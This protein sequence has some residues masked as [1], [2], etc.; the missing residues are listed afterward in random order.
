M[1]TFGE[2][3]ACLSY[4]PE[5]LMAF[6]VTNETVKS[7][8]ETTMLIGQVALGIAYPV[9]IFASL[10]WLEP[11]QVGLV[12]LVLAL[13]RL[14]M[15]RMSTAVAVAK[16]A[17]I[18]VAAVA[19]VATG[20]AI[21]ND[22]IGLLLAPTLVNVAL[23]GTFGLSLWS[24]QSMVERFARSQVAE[25]PDDE[26]AYCRSVTKV[27]CVFF[28]ANGSTALYLALASDV[29][30]WVLF[31][32]LVSY[33]LIGMLF[34]VEYIYRHWKFRRYLGGFADSFLKRYFPP[35]P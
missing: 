16:A 28:V 14:A 25:L 32:G 29:E 35:R 31:T 11:R 24:D 6:W 1:S 18:P 23:L 20:T 2:K 19:L 17:W 13:V 30:T 15:V 7:P 27:W 10:T 12:V 9:L 22:P 4:A 26:V 33:L 21:L 3:G 34:T 5:R 8:S